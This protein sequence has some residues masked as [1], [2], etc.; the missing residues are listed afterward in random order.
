[1]FIMSI[2][3]RMSQHEGRDA[4]T[5]ET[6]QELAQNQVEVLAVNIVQRQLAKDPSIS[7]DSLKETLDTLNNTYK[8]E[9]SI[10]T[11]LELIKK[12]G[13]TVTEDR[14]YAKGVKEEMDEEARVELEEETLNEE[15]Q[16]EGEDKEETY[17][18]KL[19]KA[20]KELGDENEEFEEK[21][22]LTAL[23]P[24]IDE[25]KARKLLAANI[26]KKF[27]FLDNEILDRLV[28][29]YSLLYK[30]RFKYYSHKDSFHTGEAY[31]NSLTREFIHDDNG[32]LKESKGLPI[33]L[34]LNDSET[35]V[36][37]LVAEK[38]RSAKEVAAFMK[39]E[40]GNAKRILESLVKKNILVFIENNGKPIYATSPKL[41]MDL[42]PNP[43]HNLLTSI[44]KRAITEVE[45]A[46]LVSPNLTEKEIPDLLK[47]LWGNIAVKE[48]THLFLPVW[49][50]VLKKKTGEERIV[51]IDAINGRRINEA[52]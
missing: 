19:I 5:T 45:T 18:N 35:T 31:I 24:S 29:K 16:V 37:K 3:P 40:E 23:T 43:L 21:V 47:K 27:I 46:A 8:K 26:S 15:T 6:K 10:E 11:I 12:A 28:M 14:L 34:D 51:L 17:A 2:R 7:I 33:F 32:V 9:I 52:N 4:E 38:K 48:V 22:E 49:E 36:L 39:M 44:G 1:A 42:P 50:G 13:I 41:E 25:A 30:V 20:K